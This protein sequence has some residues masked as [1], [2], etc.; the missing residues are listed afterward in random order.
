MRL[1]LRRRQRSY[2]ALFTIVISVT[3]FLGRKKK[4][5]PIAKKMLP[6]GNAAN[7]QVLNTNAEEDLARFPFRKGSTLRLEY[8]W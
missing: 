3:N 6:Q 7:M 1:S 5:P 8:R 4:A 2:L